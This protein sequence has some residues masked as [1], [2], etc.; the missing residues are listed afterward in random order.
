MRNPSRMSTVTG[1]P[2]RA[3][4]SIGLLLAVVIITAML[5][6]PTPTLAV[7]LTGEFGSFAQYPTWNGCNNASFS[8]EFRTTQRVTPMNVTLWYV[9]DG[10]STDFF[11]LMI[12]HSRQVR[13]VLQLADASDGGVEIV[14]GHEVNDGHWH[15]VEV[16]RKRA[17]TFL[18]VDNETN[19]Q[20]LFGEHFHFGQTNASATASDDDDPSHVYIG[21]IPPKFS[22]AS[23]LITKLAMPSVVFMD[24]FRGSFRNVVYSNCTCQRSRVQLVGGRVDGSIDADDVCE[25]RNPC[26]DGCLCISS[27]AGPTCDCSDLVCVG[28]E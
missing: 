14:L 1:L 26:R 25:S 16:R 8:F 27:D 6:V 7:R 10:G 20:D 15:R 24:R 11:S 18:V 9:D 22:I 28:G 13:L 21:G 3:F 5:V 19:S 23:G 12:V 2:T 17:V 4:P